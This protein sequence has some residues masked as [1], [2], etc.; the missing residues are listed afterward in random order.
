MPCSP[1]TAIRLGSAVPEYDVV[2]LRVISKRST[3][4]ALD[5]ES[6]PP[7]KR[8]LLKAFGEKMHLDLKP[9][10]DFNARLARMKVFTAETQRNGKLKYVED[11]SSG[12]PLDDAV[13][14]TY[15]DDAQMAAV[16]LR[17]GS[18]GKLQMVSDQHIQSIIS[19][20]HWH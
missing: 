11:T 8:V 7:H 3:P 6:S 4:D 14:Q 19:S 16:L 17:H 5:G 18:D 15:H 1:L 12:G 10:A 13:G 2:H 20:Q 9:N